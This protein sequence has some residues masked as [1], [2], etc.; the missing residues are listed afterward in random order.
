MTRRIAFIG[1]GEAAQAF[2]G[3]PDWRG[4]ATAFDILFDDPSRDAGKRA[5]CVRAGVTAAADLADALAEAAVV[6]SLVT[7]DQAAIAAAAA[8]AVLS[9]GTLYLDMNSVAPGTKR[10]AAAAITAAG[11]RY[12]DVAVMAPVHPAR[13]AVP[14][15][16][17]G[18]G[19]DE[20]IAVLHGIGFTAVRAVAGGVGAAAAIKMLRSVVIKGTEALTAECL[21]AAARAGLVDEVLAALGDDWKARADYNLDRMLVHGARRAAELDEVA[22]TLAGLGVVPS[23]TR[24]AAGYQRDLAGLGLGAVAGLE[25]KLAAIAGTSGTGAA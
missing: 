10:T 4:E 14:L 6:L 25:A 1:F 18:A 9:P 3:A 16:V 11:G 8:A 21:I 22:A 13:L 2:A 15:L 24:A 5:D 23:L 17:G 7:A 20:A 19:A 12:V